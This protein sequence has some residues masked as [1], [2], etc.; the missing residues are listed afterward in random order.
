LR[1]VCSAL[2]E[3][4]AIGLV[5]R[6]IKPSNVLVCERGGSCEVAKVVDFGLVRTLGMTDGSEKLTHE[7]R[8]VGTPAY[9]SPEQASGEELI[10]SRTD[11]Y[12]VGA[13]AYFALTGQP[14]FLRKTPIQVIAAHIHEKP[15]PL[16]A[17]IPQA[18]LDLRRLLCAVWKR[19]SDNV[20][21]M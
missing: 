20:S 16:T 13:V 3:A 4:H 15:L 18:P 10:D 11:I 19:I 14:P 21:R 6:D 2:A 8:L 5:H 17:V 12:S 9:M 1:Q 7:G